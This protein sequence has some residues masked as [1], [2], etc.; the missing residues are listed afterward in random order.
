MGRP[1]RVGVTLR[2][3]QLH[4]HLRSSRGVALVLAAVVAACGQSATPSPP[5]STSPAPSGAASPSA[6]AAASPGAIASGAPAPSGGIGL[7]PSSIPDLVAA[8]SP[9]VVA[10][11]RED[12]GE[13]SGVIWSANGEI[14]TNDHVVAGLQN[15]TVV[16]AD[17]SREDAEVV[18]SDERSDLAVL[19]VNR[20]GLPAAT[21]RDDLP[22]VG[23]LALAI[24]NPL[25]FEESVTAG[26]IS[27]LGRAIPGSAQ[28]APALIDLIQTDAAIS[29]GNSG[30]ALVGADGRVIG[31]NVAYIPPEGG[32]VSIG[33][34]I[35]APT[36]ISVVQQLLDTGRVE[37]AYLGITPITLDA[38][39]AEAYGL[40]ID[41]G[42]AVLQVLPDGPAARAG[43]RPGDVI[44]SFN[45]EPI[46]SAEDLLVA[47]RR[48]RV[49]D[50]VRL[51]VV[52]EGQEKAVEV[53]LGDLPTQVQEPAPAP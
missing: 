44:V 41:R 35:P 25:G 6:S 23:E 39:T 19:R 21:F 49:G 52:R 22:R 20:Q 8:V 7:L 27:G 43:I 14:V 48:Q 45:D 5:V 12:G 9:S 2:A 28:Q 17:A 47:L 31:I 42:A 16:F 18:A 24:G 32:A 53:K 51:T 15:V 13:G 46:N 3:M 26:I 34:A 37:H 36:A 30:G 10:I 38:P 50:Q 33:F 40:S 29:P 4:A 1:G 11:L